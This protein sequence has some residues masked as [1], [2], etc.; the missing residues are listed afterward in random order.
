MAY[1]NDKVHSATEKNT[2]VEEP[3]L[4]IEELELR[5]APSTV[6][7]TAKNGPA[8]PPPRWGT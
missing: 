7:G 8:P 3:R 4:Q 2:A 1:E 6:W 5:V